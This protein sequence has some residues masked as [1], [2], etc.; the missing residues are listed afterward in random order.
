[1]NSPVLAKIHGSYMYSTLF[2]GSKLHRKSAFPLEK[3]VW[4]LLFQTLKHF[5]E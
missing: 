2:Q 1:M 5:S 4:Y 3:F